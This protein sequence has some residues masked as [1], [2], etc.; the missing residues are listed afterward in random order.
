MHPTEPIVRR[1]IAVPA[2]AGLF[3]ALIAAACG[4]SA[5]PQPAASVA[6]PSVAASVAA[7]V[8]PPS[9]APSVASSPTATGSATAAVDPAKDLKIDPPFTLVALDP[10]LE[11]V[12]KTQMATGLGA[13]GQNVSFGF[14]QVNGG[15]GQNFVLALGF[16]AG[17]MTPANFQAMLGGVAASMKADLKVTTV[18]G[19]EVSSGKTASGALAIFNAGG[20]HLIMVI[21]QA[22]ADSLP[23]AK[24]LITANT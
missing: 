11:Q 8:A 3:V 5:S 2:I 4:Q 18:E 15:T 1:R 16:P 23:V 14:K 21:S 17:T 13:F 9:V 24:A 19:V 20:D 12:M 10:A 6:A 7:S 22:E